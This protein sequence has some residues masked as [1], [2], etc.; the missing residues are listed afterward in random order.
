MHTLHTSVAQLVDSATPTAQNGQVKLDAQYNRSEQRQAKDKDDNSYS[1]L[2]L[3]L[4][5]SHPLTPKETKKE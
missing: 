4:S 1:V 5:T 3:I 2:S